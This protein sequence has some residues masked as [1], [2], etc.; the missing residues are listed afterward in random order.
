M[1]KDIIRLI[2]LL[3]VLAATIIG[4]HHLGTQED[5]RSKYKHPIT[6]PGA[7]W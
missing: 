7:R 6:R 5:N 1:M 2:I 4:I 3:G